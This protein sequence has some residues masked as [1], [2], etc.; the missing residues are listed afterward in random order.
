MAVAVAERRRQRTTPW[1][2]R[3]LVLIPALAL[4]ACGS[5]ATDVG[6]TTDD[7]DSSDAEV[8]AAL[9]PCDALTA[10]GVA[11]ALDVPASAVT[12]NQEVTDRDGA[13]DTCAYDVDSESDLGEPEYV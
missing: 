12:F 1:L 2:K 8:I 3:T 7:A 13:D 9:A 5:D 11:S 10:D 4:V 6:A